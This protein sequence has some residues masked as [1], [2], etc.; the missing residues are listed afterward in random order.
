MSQVDLNNSD[1]KQKTK[2][3]TSIVRMSTLERR[4]TK[5]IEISD[6]F[7]LITEDLS[8]EQKHKIFEE[9]VLSI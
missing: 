1:I 4:N 3:K 2:K 8:L 6:C 5:K 7:G 9:N